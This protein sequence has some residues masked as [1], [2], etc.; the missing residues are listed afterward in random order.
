MSDFQLLCP[1]TFHCSF[2]LD[3]IPVDDGVGV[4]L[5]ECACSFSAL[6]VMA[7]ALGFSVTSE[8]TAENV[9]PGGEIA[10]I[11]E[12]KRPRVRQSIGGVDPP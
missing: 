4:P 2:A 10:V 9:S 11:A 8:R 3:V 1:A 7:A 12:A 5:L 6:P